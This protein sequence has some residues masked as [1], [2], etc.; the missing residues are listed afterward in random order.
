MHR[1]DGANAT[2]DNKFTLGNPGAGIPATTVTADILNAI[3]E[4]IC[5]VIESSGIVLNKPDNTQLSQALQRLTFSTGDGKITLKNVADPGW[6]LANDGTIGNAGSGATNRANADTQAL[7][8]L[9]WNNIANAD[10]PVTG[11]R[12]VSAAADFTA[13]KPIAL[14]RMLGRA[15]AVAGSGAGLTARTLGASFGAETH[16]L[17]VGEMPPH[18]HVEQA[19]DEPSTAANTGGYVGSNGVGAGN[20]NKSSATDYAGGGAAHNNMQPTTFVNV[21]IKL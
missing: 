4:E 19:T 2:I 6:V 21:M 13:L 16:A 9:L 14:T 12:G 3:Q 11:G 18:N 8:T 7:Y 20:V 15:L 10:A 5:K 1:I 17:T